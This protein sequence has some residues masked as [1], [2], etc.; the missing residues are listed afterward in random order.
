MRNR[1]EIRLVGSGG[2][3]VILASVILA[4]AAI[5]AGKNAAQ[6]QSYG[7]EARGGACMA[8][9][10]ISNGELGF[11]KVRIPSFLMALTEQSLEKYGKNL[12]EDCVILVDSSL[13]IPEWL[14]GRKVYQ[15]PILQAA[16]EQVG[17]PQTANIVAVAVINKLLDLVPPEVLK[18]AVSARL[19]GDM[20]AEKLEIS[21]ND[22]IL[23]RKRFVY[24]EKGVPVEYNIGYYR[25]DS[26]TYT[27][28]AS[29]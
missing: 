29:R 10:V 8:Q 21:P 24:D 9:A 22:P 23:I 1:E 5:L 17:K 26:F 12:P 18:E 13:E 14:A 28:E 4:E 6:S 11:P 19:A 7:P 16:I 20:V 3:G 15:A 27:I 25:A 2:Q